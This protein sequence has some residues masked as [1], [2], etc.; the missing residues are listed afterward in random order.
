M[1]D[2]PMTAASVTRDWQSLAAL[3]LGFL[4]IG[5][6][7]TS[8]NLALA[9]LALDMNLS[10]SA[11]VWVV[12]AYLMTFGGC[13]LVGGRLGDLFGHCR[14]F[15]LG[16]TIFTIASFACAIAPSAEILLMCRAAQGV[17]A[18]IASASALS[19]I[20]EIF[21]DSVRRARAISIRAMV[22]A[23]GSSI[24][25]LFGGAITT[26][27]G[28]RGMFLFSGGIGA[29]IC[30]V[31]FFVL[32]KLSVSA[33]TKRLECGGAAAMTSAL[34][35]IV[36]VALSSVHVAWYSATSL[37]LL[38]L[39]A[40]LFL[41]FARI[42]R[43]AQVPLLPAALLRIPRFTVANV[44]AALWSGAVLAG[45][46]LAALYLQRNLHLS[47]LQVGLT[48]LPATVAGS[49]TALAVAPKLTLRFGLRLPVVAGFACSA[50]GLLVLAIESQDASAARQFL[51]GLL[52]LGLGTG[53]A[54]GPLLLGALENAPASVSGAASGM[55][56]SSLT[57]GGAVTLAVL[58][59]M[60]AMMKPSG[61]LHVQLG[62][63]FR[64][65]WIVAALF[66]LSAA[67]LW[68]LRGGGQA[69]KASEAS[70]GA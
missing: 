29:C 36:Y 42:D 65:A 58:M 27:H 63:G 17:G 64:L 6:S 1:S 57:M 26:T 66:A 68:M 38:L 21:T 8:V 2:P 60:T 20:A 11:L 24:G 32:P 67:A 51:P 15:L 7:S 46:V 43:R 4:T 34:L 9:S 37:C 53:L 50:V 33:R 10:E 49:V 55:I 59:G 28:W 69:R 40:L 18:A 35:L 3:C 30:V 16:I 5:M 61:A 70:P 31:A 45:N 54:Y 44:S 48:F 12:N 39:A 47:P 56:N 19:A 23:S 25:L 22:G 13:L 52:M 41:V 14:M 62:A